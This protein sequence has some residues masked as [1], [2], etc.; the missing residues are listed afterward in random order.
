MLVISFPRTTKK[1]AIFTILV[2][3]SF[4]SY[5]N[6]S[7]KVLLKSRVSI[8]D[9]KDSVLEVSF[10]DQERHPSSCPFKP[11]RWTQMYNPSEFSGK[12]KFSLISPH[13]EPTL[14]CQ[15]RNLYVVV[16]VNSAAGAAEH[17][18]RRQTIRQTW[19]N[20]DINIRKWR[21]FFSLGLS[22]DIDQN[23]KSRQEAKENNDVIIGKFNDSYRNIPVKTFMGHWWA[24]N[25]L[26]CQYVLKTD[27]DV[28]VRVPKLSEWLSNLGSP[29]RFYG[30]HI[31][32]NPAVSRVP[33]NRWYISYEQYK[34]AF[35]PPFC[36]GAFHVLSIDLLPA[37]FYYTQVFKPFHTDDAYLGVLARDLGVQVIGIPGFN[38]YK[39][40]STDCEFISA[41][42]MGNSI[43]PH[44]MIG[45]HETYKKLALKLNI[46]CS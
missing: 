39:I 13:I 10:T 14:S 16:M 28:Y 43:E 17:R 46:K 12:S 24:F 41:V 38:S 34:E 26:S 37:Y 7:S 22:T 2:L 30:G 8:N 4:L 32:K 6:F 33:K 42:A 15:D 18:I 20:S 3:S 44:Q 23:L 1:M 31:N 45:I 21:L 25:T 9:C 19:R 29:Q 35:W 11:N 40:P 36:H 5:S 27:D